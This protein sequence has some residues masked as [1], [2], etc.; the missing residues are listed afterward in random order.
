MP[1]LLIVRLSPINVKCD[2]NAVYSS[3]FLSF[4]FLFLCVFLYEKYV[5]GMLLA[6]LVT[7]KAKSN[8]NISNHCT[9][10]TLGNFAC[11]WIVFHQLNFVLHILHTFR[12]IKCH[13]PANNLHVTMYYNC[14]VQSNWKNSCGRMKG[15][16]GLLWALE[17]A[18]DQLAAIL[19]RNIFHLLSSEE[20]V[21]ELLSNAL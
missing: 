10:W 13:F 14:I 9:T 6:W 2:L 3:T 16:L 5:Y 11:A 1:P 8:Q 7:K 20:T 4:F 19:E 17:R 18:P 15:W 21:G 12:S